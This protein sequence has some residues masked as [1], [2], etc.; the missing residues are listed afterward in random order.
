MKLQTVTGSLI[1]HVGIIEDPNFYTDLALIAEDMGFNT[2][3]VFCSRLNRPVIYRADIARRLAE[4]HQ[5]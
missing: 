2:V 5:P 1:V 4:P 3:A